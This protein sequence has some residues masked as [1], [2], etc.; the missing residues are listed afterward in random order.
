MEIIP[1]T[2]R[3]IYE[4][5]SYLL[6]TEIGY[7]LIDTGIAKR[8]RLFESALQTAGCQPHD[9]KLILI[10]HGHTD[11]V[12]NA[13]Y[14]RDTYEAKIAMHRAD[15]RIVESG[16]MF[17]DTHR[18]I[19]IRLISGVMKLLGLNDYER[20][21]PDI[22]LEDNLDLSE[23]GFDAQVIHTPGHSKGSISIR[24]RE[25]DVFCGDLLINT[26]T[27]AKN[28]LI[29]NA[30]VLDASVEK[31]RALVTSTIYPGHGKP[32]TMEQLTKES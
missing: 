21:T 19:M 22:Y 5:T 11:H 12:G 28:T 6:H 25:G 18:G 26:K 1:I 10:T 32:F 16:D 13:A 4:V 3:Y 24:T 17:I 2:V 27:P 23:Y 20:F 7:F 31:L 29:Q 14:L 30:D 15:A 9:L 8:R